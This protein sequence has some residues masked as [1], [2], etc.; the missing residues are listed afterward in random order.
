[1]KPTLF[2]FKNQTNNRI[3]KLLF[4]SFF[5]FFIFFANAQVGI[6]TTSPAATLDITASPTTGTTVEGVLIP[7][8]TRQ[9]AKDMGTNPSISTLIYVNTLDGVANLTAVNITSVGF[10]FF[11]GTV[12]EKLASGAINGWMTT[13]N[14]G[15]SGT[16]NFMGTTDNVDVAFRRNNTAAGKIGATST[17]F[18]VGALN[19]GVTSNSAAFGTNALQVNT[20]D[21]NVAVGNGTLAA[22]TTGIQNTGVGNAALAANRGSASTGIGYRALASNTTG[23]NGTAVGFEA[24]SRNTTASNNT[25]VGF[26]TLT[27]N[28]TGLQNTSTG[29]Q[30]SYLISTGS[31][32]TSVGYSA[33]AGNSIGNENTAIGN[34]ALGRNTGSGNTA[35]G[36]ESM[37]GSGAAFNNSTAVGWHAL[38]NNSASNNTAVGYNALQGNQNAT[39][40]T[41]VGSQSLNNNSSGTNNT[42]V[43]TESG[44]GATSSNNTFIGHH[45]GRFSTGANNTAI[46]SN[47]LIA[48]SPSANNVAIGYGALSANAVG[49]GNVALG[50]QA[51]SAETSSNKLYIENSNADANGAL[52]YG[53]FDT[54]IVRVNG[55]LQV[56]NPLVAG[57]AFPTVRGT[58]GYVLQTNGAGATSW[59]PI[60]V[61]TV[62]PFTTTGGA[63][64]IYNVSLSHYTVRVYNDVSEVRLPTAV[65]NTGKV[66][67]I[68]GSNG[69]G[70]KILSTAGGGIYDDVTNA[71]ITTISTNE[72]YMVQSDGTGWLVIGR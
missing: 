11:N 56:N 18:G 38:F 23:N 13:G 24:L 5:I 43:G 46:G 7:R 59:A 29:F 37:F 72:R 57:Y 60:P 20:G 12:W 48:N 44:F 40:N 61:N 31:R 70:T 9:R 27:N 2:D 28:T 33:L 19:S 62:N 34:Y 41:A 15:L 36:H 4:S 14:A 1:L 21:N 3:M 65:G 53:E 49:S 16:T 69:I 10:Y 63:T 66:F 17:S 35:I 8:V 47:T 51:G 58:N 25:A 22:N 54:N 32:N 26:Q 42:A 71:T 45:S 6:G 30:A 55:T 64:G 50:Y 39:G 68:I 67:I 52:I